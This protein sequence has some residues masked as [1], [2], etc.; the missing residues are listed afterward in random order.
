M[1]IRDAVEDDAE[2]MAAIADAPTDVMRN[3]IH[4]RTVR[5][6]DSDS[7]EHP[8][9]P[10][11]D[12]DDG[13]VDLLGFVSYDAR[14]HTVHITQLDGTDEA[15]RQL[16]GEPVRFAR[17]ESMAVELLV[18]ESASGIADAAE[19]V[20]FERQGPGPRFDGLSTVRYR[21]DPSAP[22]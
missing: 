9:D 12:T 11:V 15:C 7:A 13:V 22:S 16:L 19:R 2:A 8:L 14:E 5:V 3:L 21:L 1:E 20:G 10:N 6:A 18:P 4:D 17:N